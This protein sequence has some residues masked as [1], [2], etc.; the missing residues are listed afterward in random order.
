M[1]NGNTVNEARY[2]GDAPNNYVYFNCDE[3]QE[4]VEYNYAS[5]CEVWRILGTF[6]VER[7]DPSDST[8]TI[9]ETRMKLVRG[10]DLATIRMWDNRTITYYPTSHHRK[11]E[12][13]TKI[14][15]IRFKLYIK[16]KEKRT[17]NS[18]QSSVRSQTR[19]GIT[20]SN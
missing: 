15:L 9:T 4:G 7:T 19:W 17:T 6:D 12:I 11:R 3:P 20:E 1:V 10:T 16:R 18:I 13:E 8:K 14:C 5:S 2:I